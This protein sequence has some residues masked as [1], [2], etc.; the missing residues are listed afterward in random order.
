MSRYAFLWGDAQIVRF[1][2]VSIAGRLAFSMLPLGIVL[3]ARSATGSIAAAG[4]A[5][6]AFGVT[7][8]LHPLRGHLVDRYGPA[9]LAAF[10]ATFGVALGALV[11]V[12]LA[13]RSSAAVI[14]LTG[15]AGALVPPIGPFSRAVWGATFSD[16]DR[17]QTAYAAD[18][19]LEE[20]TLVVA[21]L[22]VGAIAAVASS[23]AALVVAAVVVA[24]G[25]T[26][27]AG[28]HLA[29]RPGRTPARTRA[30]GRRRVRVNRPLLLALA[31]LLGI[32]IALG[33]LDVAVPAFAR[34]HG[35]APLAGLLV[36]ALSAGSV[37]GGL[38]YGGRNWPQRHERRY[39]VIVVLFALALVP[40]IF[41]RTPTVLAL[42]L[43]LSGL[44]LGPAF[45]TLFMLVAR[46]S[47]QGTA[48][49]TFGLVTTC[50]NGGIAIGAAAAGAL[51]ASSGTSIALV[52]ACAGGV[53]SAMAG[54]G[55]L[56][57]SRA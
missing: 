6:A 39:L 55:L 5:V 57:T 10:S 1:L 34:E 24:L 47:G 45:I 49:R 4:G 7:S 37:L 51:V 41:A 46:S 19:T 38:W 23:G 54:A 28:S 21:P 9:V 20:L 33:V 2:G 53:L 43:V 13:T 12:G 42:L 50:N 36:A 35:S 14:V 25:G 15:V 27:T 31:S 26:G 56:A 44:V 16:S 18:S 40:L 11:A 29:R 3:F 32:G 8:A 22:L 30:A 48:T 52:V 17:L